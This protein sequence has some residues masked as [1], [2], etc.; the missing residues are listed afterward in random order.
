MPHISDHTYINLNDEAALTQDMLLAT[1]KE[2]LPK[3]TTTFRKNYYTTLHLI[4]VLRDYMKMLQQVSLT[5]PFKSELKTIGMEPAFAKFVEA[6]T[7]SRTGTLDDETKKLQIK[8]VATALT[9]F[10]PCSTAHKIIRNSN[11]NCYKTHPMTALEFIIMKFVADLR[12]SSYLV[13]LKKLLRENGNCNLYKGKKFAIQKEQRENNCQ[14]LKIERDGMYEIAELHDLKAADAN[15]LITSLSGAA[16]SLQPK[17]DDSTEFDADTAAKFWSLVRQNDKTPRR[18]ETRGRKKSKPDEDADE[19]DANTHFEEEEHSESESPSKGSHH[20]QSSRKERAKAR[21]KKRKQSNEASVADKCVTPTPAKKVRKRDGL[22]K[23]GEIDDDETI[24]T[25][26]TNDGSQTKQTVGELERVFHSKVH[27]FVNDFFDS[28]NLHPDDGYLAES[29]REHLEMGTNNIFKETLQPNAG[30]E[31]DNDDAEDG[32]DSGSMGFEENDEES[33]E[34]EAEDPA[35]TEETRKDLLETENLKV[36]PD[37]ITDLMQVVSTAYKDAHRKGETTIETQ[38]V[39]NILNNYKYQPREKTHYAY[40]RRTVDELD[41]KFFK[42]SKTVVT[43]Y[44]S[45]KNGEIQRAQLFKGEWTTEPLTDTADHVNVYLYMLC[46]R[47]SRA[48]KGYHI[49]RETDGNGN[50]IANKATTD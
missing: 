13:D 19:E 39:R 50:H 40:L 30:M 2:E 15:G 7:K 1:I 14:S 35:M 45:D 31:V 43:V 29:M 12:R 8:A 5:A 25:L 32:N 24:V 27:E 9:D 33:E 41:K 26:T 47:H 11:S 23:T 48:I 44:S 16:L 6:N 42:E 4:V 18:T 28:T 3:T 17:T 20:E 34:V 21:G 49:L 36:E 38:T 22:S 46:H 10:E 37:V